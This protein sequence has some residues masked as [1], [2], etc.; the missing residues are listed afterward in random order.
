MNFPEQ[1]GFHMCTN[2]WEIGSP[3]WCLSSFASNSYE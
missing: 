2:Q 1:Q 3:N